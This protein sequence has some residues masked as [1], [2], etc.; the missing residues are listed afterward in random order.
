MRISAPMLGRG[1]VVSVG[2]DPLEGDTT[3]ST[4]EMDLLLAT[5]I[6]YQAMWICCVDAV[7]RLYSGA[8]LKGLN[9]FNMVHPELDRESLA[10]FPWQML[11]R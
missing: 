11:P 2:D 6:E 8:V 4:R 1:A 10:G 3:W 9:P 7:K 5:P